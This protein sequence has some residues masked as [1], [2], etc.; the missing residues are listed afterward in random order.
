MK[1]RIPGRIQV[2]LQPIFPHSPTI[3]GR[4]VETYG[5]Y[6]RDYMRSFI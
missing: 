1:T 4:Q 6:P 5:P 3:N 2:L